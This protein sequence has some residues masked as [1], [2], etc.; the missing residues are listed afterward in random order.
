MEQRQIQYHRFALDKRSNQLDSIAQ[1]T[2]STNRSPINAK[3]WKKSRIIEQKWKIRWKKD[4]R[5]LAD[6][7]ITMG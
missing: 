1:T 4:E 3:R 6:D 2:P 7:W 5:I